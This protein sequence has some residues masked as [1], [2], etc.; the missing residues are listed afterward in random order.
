M[1]I[2]IHTGLK[3]AGLDPSMID[4]LKKVQRMPLESAKKRKNEIQLEKKE[5]EELNQRISALDSS[6]NG[7]KTRYDFYKLK[8][9]SSHPDIIDGAVAAGAMLG[10]Y[11]V[12]VRAMARSEKELAYGFPDKNDTPVGFGYMLIE[13]DDGEEVEVVVEPYTTLQEVAEQINEADAGVRAM[14][15]NTK[16]KPDP[17]RLLVVSEQSG[18]EASIYL[19]EDTTFLEFKE[20]VTGRNLDVLFEDVPVTDEDNVLDELIDGVTLNIRRSEPGTRVQISVVHDLDATVE[21]IQQ[22]INSY[23]DVALF[24]HNQFQENP[25]TGEYG[26]L[27]GDSSIK[28]IMR[29][30]QNGVQRFP[31][32]GEKFG[33][34]AEIGITTNPKTG[35]LAM[36]DTKVRASLTEDYDSVAKLFIRSKNRT[37]MAEVLASRIRALRDPGFGVLKSRMRGLDRII[38]Q[39]DED[40]ERRTRQ[41]E[42]KEQAID[43]QFT[44]LET[45]LANLKGQSDFLKARLGGAQNK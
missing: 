1:P 15:I 25:E 35:E 27:S 41:I 21:S 18:R 38:R 40:I 4:E 12:E 45:T 11:E 39:K 14:V 8:L 22:F 26:I 34:L 42:A 37:G 17:Y 23:N 6:L 5:F 3:Q 33:T 19:D 2:R 24:I 29:Q 7:L 36:D 44:T 32:G 43:R 20:Q 31:V 30:L 13:R 10:N 9:D 16:Y 28:M